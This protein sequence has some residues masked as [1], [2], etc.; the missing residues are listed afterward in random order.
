MKDDTARREAPV[1]AARQEQ[2]ATALA[3][4]QDRIAVACVDSGRSEAEQPALIVVTKF[5]PAAD[6]AA[7]AAL[8]IQDLGEN[9]EH[10]AA[11]KYTEVS[12]L[13][14]EASERLRWHFIGQLQS[15]KA[16]SVVRYASALHSIDRASLVTALARALPERRP[17]SAGLLNCFIQVDL[18]EELAGLSAQS[19]E[20][21]AKT[22]GGAAPAQVPFLAEQIA[23]TTG[24][25]L[26]GLMAV[27]PLPEA[28]REPA[29]AATPEQAFARLA[30]LSARLRQEHP[31]AVSISAGMSADLEAAVAHGATHLRVGSDVLG[32]RPAVR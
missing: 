10:E 15:N 3:V 1:R 28:G 5:H 12:E 11:G 9:R 26:A 22:R 2:L 18:D 24:L 25:E 21:L 8:G 32:P 30:E 17:E 31:G 7:L 6:V 29:Y 14:G 19:A 23:Q 27:A 20:G 16:K 13:L 4:V